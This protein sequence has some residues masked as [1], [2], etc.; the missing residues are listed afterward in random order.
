MERVIQTHQFGPHRVD[1]VESV[2]DDGIAGYFVLADDIVLTDPMLPEAPD[3]EE[4]VRVYAAWL[5]RD[6]S[7]RSGTS[8]MSATTT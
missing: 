1:V 8:H 3:L 5:S 6:S 4:V 2:D 7:R